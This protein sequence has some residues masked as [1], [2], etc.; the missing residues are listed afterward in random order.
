MTQIFFVGRYL[1]LIRWYF[2]YCNEKAILVEVQT[3][4]WFRFSRNRKISRLYTCTR[5]DDARHLRP[6]RAAYFG[7]RKNT[8]PLLTSYKIMGKWK[9]KKPRTING[10][11]FKFINKFSFPE[12]SKMAVAL[13]IFDS[14]LIWLKDLSRKIEHRTSWNISKYG[15]CTR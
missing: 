8:D 1:V 2:R 11:R 10:S 15:I 14:L 5:L 7:F 9:L 12:T 3:K 6:T 13:Q 4:I